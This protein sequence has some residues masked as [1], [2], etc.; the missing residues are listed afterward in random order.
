MTALE[1][2]LALEPV[3]EWNLPRDRDGFLAWLRQADMTPAEF[4]TADVFPNMPPEL[5][6]VIYSDD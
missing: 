5:R 2:D 4:R 1:E 3:D 6:R